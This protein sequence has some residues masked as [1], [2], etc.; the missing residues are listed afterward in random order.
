MHTDEIEIDADLVRN[1]LREQTPGW[2]GLPLERIPSAGTDN[3]LFRLG[4]DLVVRLPRISWAVDD[5]DKECRW[6]PFL[7]PQLPVAV[8]AP[9]L[10]GEPGAGYPYR[11]WVYRWL[12][13]HNPSTR[14]QAAQLAVPLADFVNALH[15]IDPT[16]GP[17]ASRGVPLSDRDADTRDVIASLS[18]EMDTRAASAAWERALQASSW[19]GVPVWVHGD[20]SPGNLLIAHG[21]LGAVIDFGCLGVGDPACDL[22][23]AWNLLPA[24]SRDA[25]R[26]ALGVD[27]ATWERGRGW[28]LSIALGQLSFYAQTNPVLVANARHVL[29]ELLGP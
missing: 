21:R 5:V 2:A 12:D 25:Y 17:P 3:A 4:N 9:V 24:S 11:W 22:I 18:A 23:V 13:G 10:Q 26:A 8:P 28:A 7:A 16:G 29:R 20:L 15:R 6:L 1:L 27:D 14:R 19:T